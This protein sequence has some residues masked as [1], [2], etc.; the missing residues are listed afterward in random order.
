M[1]WSWPEK[2]VPEPREI[3]DGN[4]GGHLGINET[5]AKVSERFY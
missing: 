2:R 5:L 3:H 1:A 4:S